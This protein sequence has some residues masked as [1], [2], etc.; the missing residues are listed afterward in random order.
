VRAFVTFV[1]VVGRSRVGV[2]IGEQ[3]AHRCR[4]HMRF[5]CR[6]SDGRI[7]GPPSAGTLAYRS[8]SPDTLSA[9]LEKS[10]ALL[11]TRAGSVLPARRAG[12][13]LAAM[14]TAA[15]TMMTLAK[16]SGSVGVTP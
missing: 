3:T 5:R 9:Q 14:V 10:H 1:D 4:T 16:V 6:V 13:M 8:K 11:S 15:V 2:E 7:V 12:P